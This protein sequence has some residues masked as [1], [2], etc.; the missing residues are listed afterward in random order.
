M[1][2]G[3][4]RRC[5]SDLVLLW[6]WRRPAAVAPTQPLAWERLYAAGVPLPPQ[7]KSSEK[8]NI[9]RLGYVI[10]GHFLVAA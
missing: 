8:V 2:C 4:G 5:S 9:S 7:K 1:S 6:L 10:Y 3:A